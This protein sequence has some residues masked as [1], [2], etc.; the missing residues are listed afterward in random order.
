M[1]FRIWL[2]LSLVILTPI[3]GPSAA[4]QI[5]QTETSEEYELAAHVPGELLIRFSPGMSASQTASQMADM[6]VNHKQDIPRINVHVVKL[7]P[8]LS[9]EQAIERFS[10]R[11]GVEF[12]EPNYILQIQ[13]LNQ[14]EI[15]DQ[16]ALDKIQ[17]VDAWDTFSGQPKPPITLAT[18]DSG[19]DPTH[20]DLVDNMWSNTDETPGNGLD[21]DDNGYIDDSWGWDFVNNDNDPFDDNLHGTA[22][23]SVMAGDW[24]GD[25]V[26]GVCPWCRVMAVKVLNSGGAGSLDVVASGIIYAA[27]SGAKVI[28]LSLAGTAGMQTLEDAVNYA[29]NSGAL[30]VAGAGNDGA[31][32]PMFP[33]GYANAMAIAST[34]ESDLHSC[35]SNYADDYISVAA[36]GENILVALPNQGYG[37]GSGTS[38]ST[39]L[40]AG[41]GG[42][43][44]SQNQSRT[45]S[46][47][48][49]IIEATAV[50]LGPMGFDGAFGHGRID[51]LRAVTNDQSQTAPPDGLFS[52]SGSAT[53]YAH[54]RKLVRVPGDPDTLHMIWHTRDESSYRI[55]HANSTDDGAT[56]NLMPDVFS[57][58]NETYHSAL[59]TDGDYLYAAIPSKTG[60]E[61]EALYQILFTRKLLPD[62]DWEA[63]VP[64]MGGDL[65]TVRPDIYFD[66]S[67]GR[68]H[69]LA[70]SLDSAFVPADSTSDLYYRA[71]DT[72][73]ETWDDLQIFNPSNS[74]PRTRYAA[75]Y[76][77]GDNIYVVARTVETIADIITYYYMHTV[78]ST[79]GGLTWVDQ[80]QISSFLAFT[81]G[82]YG[83][84]LAGVGDQIYMAYEVGSNIYFRSHDGTAWSDFETLE[85][86]D[87]EN[88]NKWPTITQ[89]PDGRA[90]LLFE[91]NNELF[92][93]Y[94]DG[95]TWFEKE[96]VGPGNYAN[97][98]L[99]TS[100]DR[101]EWVSTQ[102]NG[103]PFL[104]GYDWA[105]AEAQPTPT[106][107]HIP[108]VPG[109]NLV[110]FKLVPDDTSIEVVLASI[111]GNYDL[112]YAWDGSTQSW[113][114]FDP[115]APAYS[116]TLQNLDQTRGFWIHATFP[117]ILTITG[118]PPA[119]TDIPL[120]SAS[121]G[122]NLVG[123]PSNAE[124]DLP[125]ALQ[126]H[127]VGTDFSV[128]YAYNANDPADPWKLFDRAA[129]PYS[130]DL[131]SLT[132][133]LGYWIN[134]SADHT[135]QVD[136]SGP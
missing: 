134:A 54:A 68:L 123:Y 8:G 71:Y 112:V 106:D 26:A 5:S 29:W 62:G 39:P 19:V 20:N 30:V 69:V 47:L 81:S 107:H 87:A 127:G 18:V 38:L 17:A 133:G 79:D 66:P 90:W 94:Y 101:L 78:H 102:C 23:S 41:L 37:Y 131:T 45:N 14:V 120:Y 52:A 98:K 64:I 42:L 44:L 65:H 103:S 117:I 126:D 16:W 24:D 116:N 28:N 122:W 72:Q 49:S 21:D 91:V 57:S 74:T 113:Q 114:Q 73:T 119:T 53:G 46:D 124:R 60:P 1:A 33:A 51:A 35:F 88:I 115:S 136:Y 97:L 11:P 109:W 55:R 111:A 15:T 31:N 48:K 61:P 59:T 95:S 110:S 89:A 34:D 7:P 12:V 40:V 118:T 132:P 128:V 3:I 58:S 25:G 36:P 6:G 13:A 86:G 104:I 105:S 56:W 82:E 93:R 96:S 80:E 10:H 70:S 85:L 27:D 4:A 50:D 130:N 92:M 32:A 9:V 77:H 83:I 121:S 67:N 84:S 2:T 135:W 22:V 76:A 108:L 75:L 63:A 43:L 125:G 129:P 99:G 100:A